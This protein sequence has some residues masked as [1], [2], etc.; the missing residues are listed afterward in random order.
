MLS[1]CCKAEIYYDA[2]VTADGE[3]VAMFDFNICSKC[4]QENPQQLKEEPAN[5]N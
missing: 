3:L 4:E 1:E 5:D 2:W